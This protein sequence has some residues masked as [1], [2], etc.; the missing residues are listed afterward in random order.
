MF[1]S[2]ILM[3]AAGS[4]MSCATRLKLIPRVGGVPYTAAAPIHD[5]VQLGL[6]V[7]PSSPRFQMQVATIPEDDGWNSDISDTQISGTLS[8]SWNPRAV[9]QP[10]RRAVLAASLAA[11]VGP[12]AA[13]ADLVEDL[14]ED[15]R[16]LQAEEKM[17]RS[18]DDAIRE[19]RKLELD[20][21]GL[22]KRATEDYE[23]ATVA[24]ES[25]KAADLKAQL[26][27]AQAQLDD[28]DKRLAVL[29]EEEK[30]LVDNEKKQSAKVQLEQNKYLS[31]PMGQG[32]D[33]EDKKLA[34]LKEEEKMLLDT[35]KKQSAKVQLD[36]KEYLSVPM[37]Q[38]N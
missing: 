18:V 6:I 21:K 35:E 20:Q 38:V 31:V 11:V 25:E 4:M 26:T 12:L 34:E 33:D 8:H 10:S 22:I 1:V 2:F 19:E 9:V 36:P 13:S 5:I 29:K 28:T 30:A 32:L 15:E 37:G 3:S 24:G 16:E 23:K 27:K 17:I 14:V 7:E